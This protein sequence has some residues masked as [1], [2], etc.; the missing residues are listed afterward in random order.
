MAFMS[1]YGKVAWCLNPFPTCRR[2]PMPLYQMTFESIV[3]KGEIAVLLNKCII[4]I[5]Y[6]V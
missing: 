6:Y 4:D 3:P 2:I 1:L 5:P